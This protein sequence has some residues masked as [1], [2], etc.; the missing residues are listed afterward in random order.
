MKL[1]TRVVFICLFLS[2]CMVKVSYSAPKKAKEVKETAAPAVLNL[3]EK[4]TAQVKDKNYKQA[5]KTFKKALKKDKQNADVHNML[6]FSYRKS[7]NLEKAFSHYEKAL[8]IR[9]EFPE[10]REYLGEAHIQAALLQINTLRDY[11]SKG[12]DQLA[13]LTEAFKKASAALGSNKK[14]SSDEISGGW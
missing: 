10:A 4:G 14:L 5:I 2:L 12:N 11:G 13:D 9:P 3:Y 6:A 8:N 1:I 7:G